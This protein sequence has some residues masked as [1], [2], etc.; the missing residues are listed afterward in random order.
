M[1]VRKLNYFLERRLARLVQ[2]IEKEEKPAMIQ[3]YVR[4]TIVCEI[5]IFSQLRSD[6]GLKIGVPRQT[7]VQENWYQKIGTRI[8]TL[9]RGILRGKER[10]KG[11]FTDSRLT[12]NTDNPMTVQGLCEC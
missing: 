10:K 3:K 2:A 1:C 11:G 9:L 5:T 6:Q 8:E 4:Q 12:V 7:E